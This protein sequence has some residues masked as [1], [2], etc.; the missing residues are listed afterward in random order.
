MKTL[1]IYIK[2]VLTVYVLITFYLHSLITFWQL[3]D[4]RLR[5]A[6]MRWW[7]WR[8]WQ[9]APPWPWRIFLQLTAWFTWL[10]RCCKSTR[11]GAAHNQRI[12][13]RHGSVKIVFDNYECF[14][15]DAYFLK[16][17]N[18]LK[19]VVQTTNDFCFNKLRFVTVHVIMHG[20][21][22]ETYILLSYHSCESQISTSIGHSCHVRPENPR[23]TLITP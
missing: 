20:L 21:R 16:I 19:N 10:T 3:I 14:T 6:K 2:T 12:L 4:L 5:V 11:D 17:S 15:M 23:K 1:V 8:V 7:R 9:A 13:T 22:V 18:A